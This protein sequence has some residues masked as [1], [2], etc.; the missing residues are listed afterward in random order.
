MLLGT[1]GFCRDR[2][3]VISL[4]DG[5]SAPARRFKPHLTDRPGQLR[6]AP[7]MAAFIRL[8]TAQHAMALVCL[9]DRGAANAHQL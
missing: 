6:H 4:T 3:R 5:H 8:L 9:M 1:S 2:R 7:R